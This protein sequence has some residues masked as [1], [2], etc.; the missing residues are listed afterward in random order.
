MKSFPDA[1]NTFDPIE[2]D[3]AALAAEP[4][5]DVFVQKLT[6]KIEELTDQRAGYYNGRRAAGNWVNDSRRWLIWLG[7]LALLLTAVATVIR[8]AP[9]IWEQDPPIRNFDAFLLIVVLVIYAI[10]AAISFIER[11]SGSASGYFR[12]IG[13]I[14]SIRNLWTQFQFEQLRLLQAVDPQD[15][16]APARTR[17]ALIDL[18]QEYCSKLDALAAGEAETWRDEFKASLTELGNLSQTRLTSVEK[19]LKDQRAEMQQLTQRQREARDAEKPV[20]V[21]LTI[22]GAF[23]GE[24][25]IYVDGSERT[26]TKLKSLA[27]GQITPGQRVFR[28]VAQSG[29]APREAE[30]AIHVKPGEP[31]ELSI[32]LA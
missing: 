14:I 31:S 7:A 32:T 29:G 8:I 20:H 27:L 25:T 30:K 11:S 3:A 9:P 16:S 17:A 6:T 18:A 5:F 10:M 21:N 19:Q 24:A 23:D 1:G 26:K 22:V 2:L 4:D 12:H 13:V 28:V 15:A